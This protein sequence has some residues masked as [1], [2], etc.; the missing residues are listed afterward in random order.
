MG[1]ARHR[2]QLGQLWSTRY[3]QGK[4]EI[5]GS[6]E[7]VCWKGNRVNGSINIGF[8]YGLNNRNGKAKS[9]HNSFL[10]L[11]I[12][13]LGFNTWCFWHVESPSCFTWNNQATEMPCCLP[14]LF[15]QTQSTS[16]IHPC[17]LFLVGG[18]QV[19]ILVLMTSYRVAIRSKIIKHN[20]PSLYHLVFR[21]L[22]TWEQ[23]FSMINYLDYVNIYLTCYQ[24]S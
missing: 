10:T 8:K 20:N 18:R 13:C 15:C 9:Q 22:R 21:L 17:P 12:L 2:W 1:W 16:G 23:D 11:G 3:W 14:A 19:I 7:G 5:K 6:K 4:E 24:A